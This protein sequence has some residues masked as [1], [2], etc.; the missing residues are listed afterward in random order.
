MG[1]DDCDWK[2]TKDGQAEMT[3]YTR[4]NG[5]PRVYTGA[6]GVP[7]PS[8]LK[9]IEAVRSHLIKKLA[10]PH[11]KEVWSPNQ[12]KINRRF[13]VPYEDDA[14]VP[15]ASY[16]AY[17][18]TYDARKLRC[19]DY[20]KQGGKDGLATLSLVMSSGKGYSGACLLPIPKN[21]TTIGMLRDHCTSFMRKSGNEVWEKSIC[22]SLKKN[23]WKFHTLNDDNLV[24]TAAVQ[25]DVGYWADR[26]WDEDDFDDDTD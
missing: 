10:E 16:D 7:I 23:P 26:E 13:S 1:V 3:L 12:W 11:I 8:N 25:P 9:T 20:K 21:L 18:V 15:G 19:D 5:R 22:K 17:Q 6:C 14:V 4:V 24:D 2:N